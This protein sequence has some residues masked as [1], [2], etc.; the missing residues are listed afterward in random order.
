MGRVVCCFRSFSKGRICVAKAVCE[1]L[2][3]DDEL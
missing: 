1:S 2:R 3:I